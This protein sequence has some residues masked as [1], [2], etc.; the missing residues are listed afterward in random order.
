MALGPLTLTHSLSLSHSLTHP[1]TQ[2]VSQSVTHSLTP[3]TP[4]HSLTHSLTL[5]HSL[6][7][8]HSLSLTHS[9]I[10]SLTHWHS[11]SHSHTHTH[12]THITDSHTHSLTHSLTQSLN[13]S[14]THPPT[15]SLTHI[16]IH[17]PVHAHTYTHTNSPTISPPSLLYF[18]FPSC[19]SMLSL[20]LEK[21]VTCAVIRSYN[22]WRT[23]YLV[24]LD[25][26]LTGLNIFLW[27][28][29]HFWLGTVTSWSLCVAGAILRMPQVKFRGKHNTSETS[30]RKRLKPRYFHIFD[31]HFSW[32]ARNFV[33]FQYV[34][35]QASCNFARVGSLSLW[36]IAD[37]DI[38]RATLSAFPHVGSRS[39]RR[40]AH[41]SW[42][43]KIPGKRLYDFSG[44]S[45]FDHLVG[46]FLRVLAKVLWRVVWEDLVMFL[47][48]SCFFL[49]VSYSFL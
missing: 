14:P 46:I 40:G 24:N 1:L 4:S 8:T 49:V 11:H 37:F 32:R 35:S 39:W 45:F 48:Y 13:H 27:N 29:R 10:N 2:S 20:S 43:S 34:L 7:L 26:V 15:H 21:L 30:T 31:F 5:P 25:D 6:T 17:S 36:R 18:L 12:H 23:Q 9:L 22:F 33:K 19:F 3:L 28:C 47:V 41:F 42:F 44:R 38:A 16:L